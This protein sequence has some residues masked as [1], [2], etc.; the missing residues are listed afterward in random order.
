MT[1]G[2]LDTGG[3]VPVCRSDEL[4]PGRMRWVGVK[5]ERVLVANVDG[6]FYAVSDQCGHQ[7]ASLSRGR[8]KGHEVECP[9]H[10]ARFDLRTG[11]QCGGPDGKDIACYQTL[12]VGGEVWVKPSG[13]EERY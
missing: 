13:G 8:L 1:A 4:A 12:V 3:Y 11:R 9:L 6:E 10:F 5:G 7:F 2:A